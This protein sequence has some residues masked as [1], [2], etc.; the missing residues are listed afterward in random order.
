MKVNLLHWM[1]KQAGVIAM[2][3]EL[4]GRW[5][6][7][8]TIWDLKDPSCPMRVINPNAVWAQKSHYFSQ[9]EF[10]A[11]WGERVAREIFA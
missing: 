4:T 9:E 11:L 3:A 2:T 8:T 7:V 10:V 6:K 1:P 5:I